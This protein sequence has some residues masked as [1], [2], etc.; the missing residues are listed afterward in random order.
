MESHSFQGLSEFRDALPEL[1]R[2]SNHPVHVDLGR[3]HADGQDPPGDPQLVEDQAIWN[4]RDDNLAYIGSDNY[5]ITQHEE[6]L[7]YI[8]DAVGQTVGEIDIGR[9][10]DYGERIDGM[11][12]LDGHNVD[13][14][15]L[16]GDGYVPPESELVDDP[17]ISVDEAFASDG[18]VR[19]ILG[20][21]VRFAN[22]FDA[23]ERIRLE[24]MGYRYICQN[25]LVWG[26]ETIGEF[27]QL[28]I[29]ELR[30]EDVEE[31]IFDVIDKREEQEDIIVGAATDEI[32]L[33]WVIPV[34]EEVGFG[35]RYQKKIIN[36]VR[37]YGSVTDTCTRW[38]LY[39]AITNHLD[40]QV[41]GEVNPNV[42]DRHQDKALKILTQDVSSPS[43]EVPIEEVT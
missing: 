27:T 35:A 32:P 38:E 4:A 16:V 42:Y 11:V 20:V 33:S 19:D 5:E 25:W 13:V 28:H 9:I 26:E 18:S 31:L 3:S 39:N 1:A 17:T 22:S 36:A 7:G 10:R 34:L 14:G 40:H 12:T 2:A 15:E 23:S 8:D 41:V 29:D 24:T 30:A 21:G 6:V 37:S 43:E